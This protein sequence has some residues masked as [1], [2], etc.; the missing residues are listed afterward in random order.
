M[1]LIKSSRHREKSVLLLYSRGG[2]EY[3]QFTAI[4]SVSCKEPDEN[5][6]KAAIPRNGES[7]E[8]ETFNYPELMITHW[9]HIL[10]YHALSSA[11]LYS[12]VNWK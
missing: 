3:V 4:A 1:S 9:L 10:N 12:H 11:N 7:Q 2:G 8:L 6:G 5:P